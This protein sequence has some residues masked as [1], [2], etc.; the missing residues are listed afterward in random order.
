MKNKSKLLN[1]FI[2]SIIFIGF[3]T[4]TQNIFAEIDEKE[5][6][7]SKDKVDDEAPKKPKG[8]PGKKKEYKTVE[9]FLEDGEFA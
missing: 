2:F 3:N 5:E 7:S 9:E 4:F 6:K 1:I 8:M